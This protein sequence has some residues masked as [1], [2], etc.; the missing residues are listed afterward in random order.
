MF[1]PKCGKINPDNEERCSGCGAILHEETVAAV[2]KKKGKWLKIIFAVI[3]VLI[4]LCIVV[5]LLNGCGASSLPEE[6]MTF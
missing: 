6:R 4:I 5:F 1:C 3:A 2:P